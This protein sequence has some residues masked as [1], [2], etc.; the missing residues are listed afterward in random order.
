MKGVGGIIFLSSC[1]HSVKEAA[2]VLGPG[3]RKKEEAASPAHPLEV[4]SRPVLV[5]L[6]LWSS[7]TEKGG[8]CRGIEGK[9][10]S[11]AVCEL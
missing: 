6:P 7:L 8:K 11:P 3:Y 2:A 9:T 1:S 10:K 5:F 4:A